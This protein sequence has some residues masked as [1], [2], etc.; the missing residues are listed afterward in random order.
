MPGSRSTHCVYLMTGQQAIDTV[1]ET[2]RSG[3]A[4]QTTVSPG[5]CDVDDNHGT[6]WCC[7]IFKRRQAGKVILPPQKPE[8][9]TC[10]AIEEQTGSAEGQAQVGNSQ[11][12]ID[13]NVK[14]VVTSNGDVEAS[15]SGC[16]Q[17]VINTT[18]PPVLP[19]TTSAQDSSMIDDVPSRDEHLE[20]TTRTKPPLERDLWQRAYDKLSSDGKNTTWKEYCNLLETTNMKDDKNTERVLG[21]QVA[22]GVRQSM[23]AMADKQ[24]VVNLRSKH[25]KIREQVD[26]IVQ[27][28]QMVSGLGSAVAGLDPLHAGLAWAGICV[29]LPVNKACLQYTDTHSSSST[30]LRRWLRLWM[31]WRKPPQ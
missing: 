27:V 26:R 19:T 11:A 21:V 4:G 2:T 3:A 5:D 15:N 25:I 6:S 29:V 7:F 9:P 12:P 22:D 30:T 1:M 23:K 31:V 20:H 17:S 28:I 10:V 13:G 14:K 16:T 8:N 24:W 18:I